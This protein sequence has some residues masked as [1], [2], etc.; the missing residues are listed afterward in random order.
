MQFCWP[1]AIG[2]SP[3]LGTSGQQ[4]RQSSAETPVSCSKEKLASFVDKAVPVWARRHR[5]SVEQPDTCL[6]IVVMV[7]IVGGPLEEGAVGEYPIVVWLAPGYAHC[8][9][10]EC[11]SRGAHSPDR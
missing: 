11:G 5:D 10:N 8:K 6:E 3:M 2:V 1:V 4:R 9:C 7:V